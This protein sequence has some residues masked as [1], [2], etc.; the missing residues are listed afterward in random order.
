MSI[1]DLQGRGGIWQPILGWTVR[2]GNLRALRPDQGF[3]RG[4]QAL[5]DLEIIGVLSTGRVL[6]SVGANDVQVASET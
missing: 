4:M 3:V 2:C 5:L 6:G 1:P